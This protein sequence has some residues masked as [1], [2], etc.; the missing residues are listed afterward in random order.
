MKGKKMTD[1]NNHILS[2]LPDEDYCEEHGYD[3]CTQCHLCDRC[4]P[5]AEWSDMP[6]VKNYECDNCYTGPAGY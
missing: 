5:E 4:F 6:G 3:N 2:D 1:M